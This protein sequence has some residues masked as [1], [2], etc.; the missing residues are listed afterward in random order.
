MREPI[1]QCRGACDSQL[2]GGGTEHEPQQEE[3]PKSSRGMEKLLPATPLKPARVP[4]DAPLPSCPSLALKDLAEFGVG[5][6]SAV[7]P[8]GVSLKGTHTTYG[9]ECGAM[10]TGEDLLRR[11]R[12]TS[13][14]LQRQLET[15]TAELDCSLAHNRRLQDELA[16]RGRLDDHVRELRK[17]TEGLQQQLAS[18]RKHSWEMLQELDKERLERELLEQRLSSQADLTARLQAEAEALSAKLKDALE[19][20]QLTDFQVAAENACRMSEILAKRLDEVSPLLSPRRMEHDSM[21]REKFA[22]VEQERDDLARSL[23]QECERTDRLQQQISDMAYN[24]A[25]AAES[26]DRM[27]GQLLMTS[28][29]DTALEATQLKQREL[30][31]MS[32]RLERGT[33]AAAQVVGDADRFRRRLVRASARTERGK[34]PVHLSES[35][36]FSSEEDGEFPALAEARR[37]LDEIRHWIRGADAKSCRLVL[38]IREPFLQEPVAVPQGAKRSSSLKTPRSTLGRRC[39]EASETPEDYK[40]SLQKSALSK[41]LGLNPAAAEDAICKHLCGVSPPLPEFTTE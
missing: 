27:A 6:A 14:L 18:E 30:E 7:S 31:L 35:G 15:A 23:R 36:D 32:W 29:H 2:S 11:E 39:Q 25:Q 1:T 9:E 28:H 21:L 13:R 8:R 5:A 19:S 12:Q 41:I 33:A 16:A 26:F 37:K 38:S 3:S 22:K 20:T 24:N 17:L 34:Q 40:S 4:A 10:A